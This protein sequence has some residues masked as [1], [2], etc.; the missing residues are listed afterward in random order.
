MLTIRLFRIGKKNKPTYRLIISE[1]SK[2]TRAPAL[3]TLGA[4][5]PYSKE[6]QANGERIKY[7][8]SKGA[9]MSATVNNLLLDKAIITGE[10]VKASSSGTKKKATTE[11]KSEVAPKIKPIEVKSETKTEIVSEVKSTEAKLE[12]VSE[13]KTETKIEAEP[14]VKSTEAK[15]IEVAPEIVLEAKPIEDP[16]VENQTVQQAH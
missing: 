14:E 6:L 7:W 8:L 13:V 10:K 16:V 15:P 1:K 11:V 5:N 4:Y 9:Q 3:E 2:D 12:A